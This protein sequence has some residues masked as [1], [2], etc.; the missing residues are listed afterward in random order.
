LMQSGTSFQPKPMKLPFFL[1]Q[2]VER[3]E[4]TRQNW[5]KNE[6]GRLRT[7]TSWTTDGATYHI[8]PT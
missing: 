6:A 7:A 4:Q 1:A 2:R 8:W 5:G 3:S